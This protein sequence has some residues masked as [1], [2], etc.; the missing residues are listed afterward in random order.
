MNSKGNIK[1]DI[2]GKYIDPEKIE[3]APEGFTEKI[4]IRIQVEKSPAG[5]RYKVKANVM[6][7]VISV[8]IALVFIV[9][10]V[11]YSS[12][13]DNQVITGI[14]GLFHNFKIP[15]IELPAIKSLSLP[16]VVVYISVGFL[17]L[18]LFDRALNRLF[19]KRN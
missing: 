2:L 6:V 13:S 3:K 12:P 1:N 8:I 19:H 7:P 9:L 4:M 16:S 14:A 15:S 10:A 17:F 18:S 5:V 11:I